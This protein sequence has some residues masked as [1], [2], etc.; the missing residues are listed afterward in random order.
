VQEELIG[1]VG[2]LTDEERDTLWL[3]AWSYHA[4]RLDTYRGAPA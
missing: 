2:H 1:R 4:S 3:F